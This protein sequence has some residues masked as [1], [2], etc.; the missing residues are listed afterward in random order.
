MSPCGVKPDKENIEVLCPHI[1]ERSRSFWHNMEVS[2]ASV[3]L[4]DERNECEDC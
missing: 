4:T 2:D 1:K 3:D